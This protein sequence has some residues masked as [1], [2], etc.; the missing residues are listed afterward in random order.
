MVNSLLKYSLGAVAVLFLG[1][2]ATVI[3]RA[4]VSHDGS[5]LASP[6]LSASPPLAYAAT[7]AIIL[8][9]GGIGCLTARLVGFRWGLLTTGLV[10]VWPAARSADVAA[11]FRVAGQ[12]PPLIRMAID[13][14]LIVG[15][16]ALAALLIQ[17]LARDR[18]RWGASD[19]GGDARPVPPALAA[20][21]G[22]AI[23]IAACLLSCFLIAQTGMKGQA[24]FTAVC[25]TMLAG[26][27]LR[28]LA[29]PAPA[30]SILLGA[31]LVALAGPLVVYF[32]S[33]SGLD[34]AVNASGGPPII[35]VLGFDWLAGAFL[36]LP[37]GLA[38]NTQHHEHPP[39]DQAP[40][41]RAA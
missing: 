29:I 3:L 14:F 38:W 34:R 36:G 19:S 27:L 25:A 33:T 40:A 22:V 17:H 8:L 18:F 24:I 37:I 1:P 7:A 26:A 11:A 23:S 5:A 13:G 12:S 32:G 41:P 16:G 4:C 20:A 2:L 21:I 28:A 35:R 10:A 15:L 31:A 39:A 6:L 9:A 30:F